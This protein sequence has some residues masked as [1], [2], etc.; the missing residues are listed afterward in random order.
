MTIDQNLIPIA[1]Q[2]K[3]IARLGGNTTYLST[4]L[5]NPFAGLVPGTGLNTGTTSRL[6]LLRPYPLFAGATQ[7]TRTIPLASS[8]LYRASIDSQLKLPS[9]PKAISRRK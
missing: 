9:C 2:Q 8:A 1:E 3:A 6:N 5:A 4:Q 7:F